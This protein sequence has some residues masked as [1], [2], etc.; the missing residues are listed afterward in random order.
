MLTAS[1]KVT[2][3]VLIP[4]VAGGL[5][6][7]ACGQVASSPSPRPTPLR[8]TAECNPPSPS[9]N[10]PEERLGTTA[11]GSLWAYLM[12][13]GGLPVRAGEETKI[14]WRYTVS[15]PSHDPVIRFTA[16]AADGVQAQ[17]TFGPEGHSGSTW[18]RPGYE[19]GTGFIFP[20]P[21]C[22]DIHAVADGMSGD[23]FLVVE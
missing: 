15:H 5:L 16:R 2:L 1:K 12:P 7:L 4:T 18:H 8:A 13:R 6:L 14:V 20:A 3:R 11:G 23:L 9:G 22:W 21:G 10:F 17:M 19:V